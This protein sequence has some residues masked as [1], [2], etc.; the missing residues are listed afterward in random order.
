MT[1]QATFMFAARLEGDGGRA[2]VHVTLASLPSNRDRDRRRLELRA[3]VIEGLRR[4][5]T[6]EF[7]AS[8]SRKANADRTCARKSV[9]ICAR[10]DARGHLT[11]RFTLRRG[12]W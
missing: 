12:R 11:N 1:S 6:L 9:I 3:G 7:K 5:V 8:A 2:D 4:I 10:E